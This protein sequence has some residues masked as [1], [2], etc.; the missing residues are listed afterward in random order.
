MSTSYGVA[1]IK[2]KKDGIVISVLNS[3]EGYEQ[4]EMVEQSIETALQGNIYVGSTMGITEIPA[5]IAQEGSHSFS[6]TLV[7]LKVC[8]HTISNEGL[9]NGREILPQGMSYT[10]LFRLKHNE[11]YLELT[12]SA[13]NY[14]TPWRTRY[15]YRLLGLDDKWTEHNTST[16]ICSIIYTSLPAGRY[17]LE[18]QTA[19]NGDA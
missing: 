15:R 12:L 17:V 10:H 8:N 6:P 4:G 16:G 2:E 13:L 5:H 18:A 9:L 7:G 3:H 1:W 19:M 11:N 14:E